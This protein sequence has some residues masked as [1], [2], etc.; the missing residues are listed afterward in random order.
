VKTAATALARALAETKELPFN[1]L[2][3][4]II[5][6]ILHC[7][8][9]QEKARASNTNRLLI[10]YSFDGLLCRKRRLEAE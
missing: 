9:I 4:Q 5:N 8:S 10:D 3:F 2:L 1:R 6:K 7:L